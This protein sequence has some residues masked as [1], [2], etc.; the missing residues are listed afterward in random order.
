MFGFG[1]KNTDDPKKAIE[2][3]DK[4]I[5]TGLTGF[6]TKAFVGKENMDKMNHGLD[7]AKKYADYNNVTAT[8]LPARSIK[9]C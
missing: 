9:Y 4:T 2:Q 8:G 6:F 1:K 5:N 7:M 3:A